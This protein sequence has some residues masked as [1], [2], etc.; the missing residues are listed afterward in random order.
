MKI[1]RI[2]LHDADLLLK[3]FDVMKELRPHLSFNDYRTSL[4]KMER[5]GYELW[6][7]YSHQQLDALMGIRTY[8]DLVRGFHLYIDDLVVASHA[9]SK[10]IGA[11]LLKFAED[12]AVKREIKVLRLCTG[13]ENI[14]GIKFYQREGWQ[15][16]A[17][18]FSK[19]V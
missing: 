1:R 6:G 7:H 16:R 3:T 14:A 11:S 13:L 15:E 12:I 10:G 5:E 17:Y 19:K 4:Y 8:C 9:R 18:A 2:D